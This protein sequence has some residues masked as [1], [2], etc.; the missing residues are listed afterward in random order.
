MSRGERESE[1][2]PFQELQLAPDAEP[3]LVK[4]AFK[5][6]AKKYHPDRFQ[7]PEEKSRAEARMRR[8]NEAQRRLLEGEYRPSP[9]RSSCKSPPND[10]PETAPQSAT[11]DSRPS[12]VKTVPSKSP[13]R[14]PHPLAFSA[15]VLAGFSFLLF[16]GAGPWLSDRHYQRALILYGENRV[17]EALSELN[18][19]VARDPKNG[20]AYL[21]RAEVYRSVGDDDKAETDL[22][23]ATGLL[24]PAEAQRLREHQ[25]TSSPD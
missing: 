20:R 15:L 14:T 8:I 12:R 7:D 3:E 24:G 9:P 21:L 10:P 11:T 22:R 18:S 2:D 17:S 13:N 4:A 23:N 5:A 16:L 6:L 25:N 19:A 1:F